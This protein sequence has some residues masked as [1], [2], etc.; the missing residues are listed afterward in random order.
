MSKA[1]SLYL[2][3]HQP[4]RVK[5][6]TIFQAGNDHMYFNDETPNQ[7]TNNE[8]IIRKVSEK[9][10]LPTNAVLQQLLDEHPDFKLSLSLP[11]TVIEQ[12]QAWA[13]D[14]LDSFKRLVDTGRVEIVAE[15]YF[16]SLAFFYD[17]EEFE[18]QVESHKKIVNDTFG[19]EPTGFRNT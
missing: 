2:H 8:F 1:V 11:G 18:A 14:V 19:V 15:T 6:Y 4:Y 17:R 5:P 3:V 10:Y 16:H 9:S 13:P 12:F 7:D